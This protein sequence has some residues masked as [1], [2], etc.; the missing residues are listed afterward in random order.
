MAEEKVDHPLI[1]PQV[2]YPTPWRI[3]EKSGETNVVVVTEEGM[4]AIVAPVELSEFLVTLVNWFATSGLPLQGLKR[5][6]RPAPRP[7]FNPLSLD[8]VKLADLLGSIYLYVD[9]KYVTRQLTTEQRNLWATVLENYQPGEPLD[10]DRW[11]EQP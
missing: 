3:A 1:G 2:Q 9:W 6:S 5:T 8:L 11:W 10:I 4:Q 7:M